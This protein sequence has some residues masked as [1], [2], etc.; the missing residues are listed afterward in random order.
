VVTKDQ[1]SYN[2]ETFKIGVLGKEASIYKE[3]KT[4]LLVKAETYTVMEAQMKIRYSQA[5]LCYRSISMVFESKAFLVNKCK[6]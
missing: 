3:E 2:E 5:A 6:F 4:I 1:K